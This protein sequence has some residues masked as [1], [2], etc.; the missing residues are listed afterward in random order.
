MAYATINPATGEHLATFPAHT[1]EEVE[2]AL[3]T[4]QTAYV[5]WRCLSYAK[6]AVIVNR[7]AEIM[8]ERTD[9]FSSLITLEMGKIYQEAIGETQLSADILSYYVENAETSKKLIRT[10]DARSKVL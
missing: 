3:A 10:L 9:E 1:P 2:T 5:K 8:R 6:R 7:A 4:A